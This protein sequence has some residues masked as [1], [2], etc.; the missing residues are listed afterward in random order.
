[1]TVPR[2]DYDHFL[3]NLSQLSTELLNKRPYPPQR[4]II[5]HVGRSRV[6]FVMRLLDFPIDLILPAALWPWGRLSL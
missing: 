6:R 1:M 4:D 3:P 2:L 5:L